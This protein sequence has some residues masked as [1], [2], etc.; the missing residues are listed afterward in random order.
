MAGALYECER[1]GMGYVDMVF[2]RFLLIVYE[3]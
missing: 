3:I 2:R 1:K